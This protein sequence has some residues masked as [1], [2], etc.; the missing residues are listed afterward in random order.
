MIVLAATLPTS[1]VPPCSKGSHGAGTYA[2]PGGHLEFGETFE[3]CAHREVMEETG[4]KLTDVHFAWACNTIYDEKAHYV[5][6]FM[7][8]SLAEVRPAESTARPTWAMLV[9]L[10]HGRCTYCMSSTADH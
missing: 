6:I 2:L 10:L 3:E 1:W 4:L 9:T 7:R 5:T 8:A